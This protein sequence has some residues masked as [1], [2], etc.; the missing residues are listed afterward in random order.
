MQQYKSFAIHLSVGQSRTRE[1]K[2]SK[3]DLKLRLARTCPCAENLKDEQ[4]TIDNR[5]IKTILVTTPQAACLSLP[6]VQSDGLAGGDCH[7][8]RFEGKRMLGYSQDC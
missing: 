4:E 2:L 1:P 5:S 8:D 7:R 3:S 6:V